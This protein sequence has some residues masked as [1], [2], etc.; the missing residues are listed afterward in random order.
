M[1]HPGDSSESQRNLLSRFKLISKIKA[2]G[3]PRGARLVN[4]MVHAGTRLEHAR[5]RS[6]ARKSNDVVTLRRK[7]TSSQVCLE[8]EIIVGE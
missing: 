1:L 2:A 8:T 4:K 5:A 6:L 7:L 3:I